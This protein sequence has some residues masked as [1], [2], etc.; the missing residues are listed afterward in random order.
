MNKAKT[1][2][3]CPFTNGED[4]NEV[5]SRINTWGSVLLAGH[6]IIG[7]DLTAWRRILGTVRPTLYI[8]G[9]GAEDSPN[10]YSTGGITRTPEQISASL[11]RNMSYNVNAIE[12]IKVFTCHGGNRD[13][14]AHTLK[15]R[16]S[17][18]YNRVRVF[19]YT[20]LT[21]DP[22][23]ASPHKG[24]GDNAQT[25]PSMRASAARFEVEPNYGDVAISFE[26]INLEL[27]TQ[28]TNKNWC[29]CG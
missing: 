1:F 25:G 26:S 19:G 6:L 27:T 14:A 16:L 28:D 24:A 9:H 8:L 2:A 3:W 21:W 4:A 29:A 13:G 7:D 20:K 10:I 11:E 5:Q 23:G 17:L 15:Q 22:S 12:K 18:H